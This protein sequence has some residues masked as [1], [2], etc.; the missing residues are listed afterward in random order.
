M[1][2][3]KH[4]LWILKEHSTINCPKK[5]EHEFKAQNL[6]KKKHQQK[7]SKQA[8]SQAHVG[9]REREIERRSLLTRLLPAG[10]LRY[11]SLAHVTQRWTCSQAGSKRKQMASIPSRYSGKET[12][13]LTTLRLFGEEHDSTQRK[14]PKPENK[15]CCEN[16]VFSF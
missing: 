5:S 1:V 10:S 6:W 13:L 7:G 9:A 12:A 15:R 14:R 8:C 16:W 11:S 4:Q 2:L 3:Q